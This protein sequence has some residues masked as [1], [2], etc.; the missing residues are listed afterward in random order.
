MSQTTT[1]NSGKIT[2]EAPRVPGLGPV[3]VGVF[4]SLAEAQQY[5]RERFGHRR[6]LTSQDVV[7]RWASSQKRIA[8]AGPCR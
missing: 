5:A 3:V 8:F 4:D 6:D 2:V 7:I 1:T